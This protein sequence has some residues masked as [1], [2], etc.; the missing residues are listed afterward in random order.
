MSPSIDRLVDAGQTII[1]YVIRQQS[2]QSVDVHV[3]VVLDV[4]LL[5]C[6]HRQILLL[7]ATVLAEFHS[8]HHLLV[9]QIRGYL[10]LGRL[11]PRREDLLAEE[12]SPRRVPLLRTL[13]LGILLTL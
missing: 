11:V 12:Q 3:V 4:I 2:V 7:V 10:V 6:D 8:A 9:D 13:L 5:S 1:R